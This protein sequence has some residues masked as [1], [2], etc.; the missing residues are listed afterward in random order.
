VQKPAGIVGSTPVHG[1]HASDRPLDGPRDSWLSWWNM[2]VLRLIDR[3]FDRG[4]RRVKRA[5]FTGLPTE[6]VELGPG[7]GANLRYYP[8]GSRV[9]A[10]E[11]NR[12]AHALLARE[13]LRRGLE[14]TLVSG[15]A[16][17]LPQA[18]ASV[19]LVV[20]TLVLC[21]VQD[22]EAVLREIVRVL[23]PGGRFLAIEHVAGPA[24]SAHRALQMRLARIWRWLFGGCELCRETER[25]LIAAGFAEVLID[26]FTLPTFVLPLRSQIVARCTR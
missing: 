2:A 4:Y 22:P 14:V 25:L 12:Y 8:P 13:A 24:G 5:L 19:D 17:W 10:V 1:L 18:T 9:V 20:G 16:E 15:E 26:R 21:S 3:H 23:R 11:P 6:I 7:P